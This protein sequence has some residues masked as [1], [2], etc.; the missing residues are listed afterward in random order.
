V[1]DGGSGPLHYHFDHRDLRKYQ[2]HTTTFKLISS[3]LK[4]KL[5]YTIFKKPIF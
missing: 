1:N 5:F 3:I 4:Q 2:Y